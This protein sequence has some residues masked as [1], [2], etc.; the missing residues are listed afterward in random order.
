MDLARHFDTASRLSPKSAAIALRLLAKSAPLLR[1]DAVTALHLALQAKSLR[2]EELSGSDLMVLVTHERPSPSPFGF[3]FETTHHRMARSWIK[4][5]M[6][7]QTLRGH[8]PEG[9][10]C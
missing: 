1:P 2:A 5:V 7:D 9:L 3:A 6:E 4:N 10:D 8:P